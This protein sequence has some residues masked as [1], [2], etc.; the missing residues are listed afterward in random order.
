MEKSVESLNWKGDHTKFSSIGAMY[1]I[2]TRSEVVRELTK[3]YVYCLNMKSFVLC[4]QEGG[5]SIGVFRWPVLKK[6]KTYLD[7]F[8]AICLN[9]SYVMTEN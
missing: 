5:I 4:V 9:I 2:I 1:I 3:A 8:I 6:N 7:P